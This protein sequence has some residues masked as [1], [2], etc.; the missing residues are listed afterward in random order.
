MIKQLLNLMI[1]LALVTIFSACE[2]TGSAPEVSQPIIS[3][4]AEKNVFVV[5]GDTIKTGPLKDFEQ[6][7]DVVYKLTVSSEI[8]L[9][10]FIVKTSSDAFYS[11]LK[12]VKTE[13]ANAIDSLGNFSL[14]LNNVVVYYAYRIHPLVPPLSIVKVDFTFQNE[15]HYVG[16]SSNTFTVIKKGSTSG[17]LLT[18]ID[19]PG[20]TAARFAGIGNE[21]NLDILSGVRGVADVNYRK[22]AFYSIGL[23]SDIFMTSDALL[24]A[25]KIDIVGYKTKSAG[26]DPVFTNGSF[27]LVSPSDTVVLTSTYAG[28]TAATIALVGTAGTANITVG[29]LTKTITFTGATTTTTAA[30]FVTANAAAFAAVNLTLT[31]N[32]A[33]LVWTAKIRSVGVTPVKIVTVTG[34]LFGNEVRDA[35]LDLL[36]STIRKMAKNLKAS[37]KDLR[38]VYFKRLDNVTGTNKVTPAYFDLLTHDNEFDILLAGIAAEAKTAIGP[39]NLNE[40]YGFVTDDGRR[41][42]I[43]TAPVNSANPAGIVNATNAP[44]AGDGVLFCTIKVQEK[45]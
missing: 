37:G 26:T 28:A 43:K 33:N 45:L 10:K 23:R 39:V 20:Y 19:M 27:N 1:L 31:S 9:S 42:I 7:S 35:K 40:V 38:K 18:I 13:P 34:T 21:D 44:T 11:G 8:P 36:A 32:A 24:L 12:I 15:S 14:K 5:G 29:G 3:Q 30:A 4:F 2:K 6:E 16:T 22:G 41:G 17:K 25:E